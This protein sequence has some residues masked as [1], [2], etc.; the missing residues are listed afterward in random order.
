M[1]ELK[2][3]TK[4]YRVGAFGSRGLLAVDRVSL[5]VPAGTIVSLVGESGSGKTTIGKMVLRLIRPTSGRILFEGRDVNLMGKRKLKHYYRKVQGVFQDPFS[6]YNPIFKADRIFWMIRRSFFPKVPPRDWEQHVVE[7]LK[8]VGLN[9]KEVLNKFPHQ[10]S[11]GQLQRFLIARVFLLDV[12]LLVADEIVSM[13]DASTRVE[14]LDILLKLRE[15][16]GGVL[17]ITH[18]LSLGYY[19]SDR[20]VIMYQGAVMEY[21]PPEEV[22]GNPVH[23]YTAFLLE[24]VPTLE[25]KWKGGIPNIAGTAADIK[26][27]DICRYAARCPHY[28]ESRCRD[29]VLEEVRPGHWAACWRR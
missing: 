18:D 13:L 29:P 2:E 14:V 11:G 10:L 25:R 17:F 8:E 9:P 6:S 26:D 16:G 20:I 12:K 19:L 4:V 24:A 3:V 23:P 22:F 1:L 7:A 15:R 28:N 27:R 21:G 5:D